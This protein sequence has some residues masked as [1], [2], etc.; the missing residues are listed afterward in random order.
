MGTRER[1]QPPLWIAASD[2][3]VSPGHPFYT[4]LNALLDADGFD[5]FVEDAC[6]PFYAPVLGRPSLA[7]GRYFRL[8]LVGYFE[9]HRFGARHRVARGGFA[10][11]AE[12]SAAGPRRPGAGSFDDLAHPPA[13]RCGDASGGVHVGPAAPGGGRPLKGPDDRDRRDDA[14]S[15]CGDA[16]HRATG[17]RGRLSGVSDPPGRGLGHQD[18]D[19]RGAG[20]ARIASGRRRPPTRTGRVPATPT[21][22]SRR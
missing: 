4:R 6:R 19:A 12:L 2:L 22:R 9:G 7:P 21:R 20:A 11:G 16:E 17:H 14:G 10:G 1:E 8:L 13:D 18:A 3:P 15:Q 5:A